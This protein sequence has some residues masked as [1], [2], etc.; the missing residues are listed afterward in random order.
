MTPLKPLCLLLLCAAA[1]A[2]SQAEAPAAAPPAASAT[3][4]AAPSADEQLAAQLMA[5]VFGKDYRPGHGDALTALPDSSDRKSIA[6]YVVTAV[7]QRVLA[8]G[9]AVLVANAENADDNGEAESG[10]ASPGLLNVFILK[11]DGAAWRV[12]KRHE[13]VDTLGA[14]GHFGEVLWL[15]LAPGK[16]GLGIL[17][18]DT[19]QGY[20]MQQLSLFDLGAETLRDLSNGISVHSDSEGACGPETDK[21]W[22]ISGAWRFAPARGDSAYQD[23]LIDFSGHSEAA[24]ADQAAP[25]GEATRARVRTAVHAS[26]RYAYDGKSYQLVEGENVVPEF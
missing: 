19:A 26:A 18:G 9:T 12:L 15:Q 1:S 11:R 5:A 3:A 20:T 25:R 17:H 24:Q 10:H 23:L 4:T 21:C 8:D 22:D 16:A 6:P 2:C 7:A 13:N 14:D